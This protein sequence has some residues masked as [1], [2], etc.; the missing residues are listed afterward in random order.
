MRKDREAERPEKQM[1]IFEK[2][3]KRGKEKTE[4]GSMYQKQTLGVEE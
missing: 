4:K 3:Q 1:E 2:G